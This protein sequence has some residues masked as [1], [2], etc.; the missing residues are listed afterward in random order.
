MCNVA[1]AALRTHSYSWHRNTKSTPISTHIWIAP[2][3][4]RGNPAVDS[5]PPAR[6]KDGADALQIFRRVDL[7]QDTQGTGQVK[8]AHNDGVNSRNVQDGFDVVDAVNVL[9]LK[10]FKN[11][12]VCVARYSAVLTRP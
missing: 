9:N 1:A 3:W 11:L 7:A 2:G 4:L 12:S 8:L 10:D 6:V 5:P